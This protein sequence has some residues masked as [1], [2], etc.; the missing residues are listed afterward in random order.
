MVNSLKVII[1]LTWGLSWGDK[2]HSFWKALPERRSQARFPENTTL[3]QMR[4]SASQALQEGFP[5]ATSSDFFRVENCIFALNLVFIIHPNSNTPISLVP[6]TPLCWPLYTLNARKRGKRRLLHSSAFYHLG[7]SSNPHEQAWHLIT[8][9][10]FNRRE[11]GW[12]NT[13][14]AIRKAKWHTSFLTKT[15]VYRAPITCRGH[16]VKQWGYKVM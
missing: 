3:A 5:S 12:M 2:C 11:I 16:S 1:T 10:T 14:R 6:G 7:P 4:S 15:G 8:A 13:T 9:Y